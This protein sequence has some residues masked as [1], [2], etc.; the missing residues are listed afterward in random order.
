MDFLPPQTFQHPS[1]ICNFAMPIQHIGKY[2]SEVTANAVVQIECHHLPP[3]EPACGYPAR[4]DSCMI[5]ATVHCYYHLDQIQEYGSKRRNMSSL[6]SGL[7]AAVYLQIRPGS[8]LATSHTVND[9]FLFHLL[10][11]S[12]VFLFI[13]CIV[14]G[15]TISRRSTD[16][17]RRPAAPPMLVSW[18]LRPSVAVTSFIASITWSA[19]LAGSSRG[20]HQAAASAFTAPPTFLL[21]HG[22]NFYQAAYRILASFRSPLLPMILSAIA[23]ASDLACISASDIADRSCRHAGA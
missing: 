6:R 10:S 4:D 18:G 16:A 22:A 13:P 5:E 3:I 11:L 8:A 2:Q 7:P 9:T 14:Q 21:T 12:Y 23:Q 17:V 19:D 1:L 20:Q 15:I